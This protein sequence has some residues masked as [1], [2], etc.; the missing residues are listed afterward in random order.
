MNVL[1]DANLEKMKACLVV[2]KNLS[3]KDRGHDEGWT[4]SNGS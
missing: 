1:M 3:R 2:T 4:Q